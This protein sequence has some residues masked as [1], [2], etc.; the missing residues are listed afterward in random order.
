MKK[1]KFNL[2]LAA[3]ITVAAICLIS[4]DME[5]ISPFQGRWFHASSMTIK[6]NA[7]EIAEGTCGTELTW[8]LSD[9]ILTIT[10]TG[11]M[12]NWTSYS[13]A[14]WDSYKD[15]I[16]SVVINSGVTSVGN[17]AFYNCAALKTVSLPEEL[18]SIGNYAFR[19]CS[20]LATVKLPE[21]LQTIGSNAFR[22]CT[23]LKEVRIPSGVT[24]VS[25]SA[26][27]DGCTSLTKVIFGS[28]MTKVPGNICREMKALTTVEYEEA[29]EITSIG[30]YAFYNCSALATMTIPDTVVNVE[31]N[32][33]QGCSSLA[34]VTLPESMETIGSYAFRYCTLLG[35]VRIP[36]GVTS[37]S[38]SAPFDGC[39]SLTKVIF[40]SGMT[41]VPGNICRNMKALTT[42]VYE[43]GSTITSIGSYAFYNCSALTT[44]TIPDTV[45]NVENNAFQDC[46]SL[47]TVTLPESLQTIGNNAFR[48]C[49]FLGEVRIPS[50]V[51]SVS[52]SAPFDGC[53]ALTKVTFGKGITKVP[54]NICRNMTALTTVEYEEANGITE[55]GSYAFYNCSALTT[56]PIPDT[57]TNVGSY[58]FYNCT[59]L[60]IV[61]IP[62]TVTTVENY[63]FYKCSALE[64]VSLPEGLTSIGNYAFQDC[65]SLTT[66]KLPESLT[67]IGN[68]AFRDCTSLGEVRIPSGVTSVSGSAPFTGCTALTKVIFGSGIT[69]VPENIC[70]E[71]KALTT[72][73][74]EEVDEI[75][76]IGSYAFYNCSA[77]A[78]VTI[79]DTVTTVGNNAFNNCSA[80]KE[81]S[82][83]EGL[84]SI[85][86]KAFQDCSSLAT[87]TLPESLTSI[88]N[89][90]FYSCTSL[91]KIRIPSAVTTLN[92]YTFYECASLETVTISGD[93]SNIGRYVFYGCNNLKSITFPDSLE[94]I[95]DY[96]FYNCGQL[97]GIVLPAALK[98]L[99]NYAFTNCS[100]ITSVNLEDTSITNIGTQC[101]MNCSSIKR[102]VI[103]ESVDEV[104]RQ[105]FSGCSAAVSLTIPQGVKVLGGGC[106]AGCTGLTE[107][108]IP[109][110]VSTAQ[111]SSSQGPFSGCSNLTKVTFA[112]KM[113]SVPDYLFYQC[114]Q[115]TEISLP[116]TISEIGECAFYGCTNL[117]KVN[118]PSLLYSVGEFA[119]Y[120]CSKITAAD[121]SHSLE[122]IGRSAFSGC[123]ALTE[124]SF[125]E[126]I[127]VI[128][129]SCFAG[130][131]LQKVVLPYAVSSIDSN[132]FSNINTLQEISIPAG[133]T[134]IS[135]SAFNQESLTI[136]GA[137]GSRAE[138]Y[139]A[140][141]GYTFIQ[142]T[143]FTKAILDKTEMTLALTEKE[144]LSLDI[145]PFDAVDAI[146][147]TSENEEIVKVLANEDNPAEAVVTGVSSGETTIKVKAGTIE[148]ICKIMVGNYVTGI[149]LS[150]SYIYMDSLGDT[151]TLTA[152]VVPSDADNAEIVWSSAN[153]KVAVVDDKGNITAV[154]N[155]TV[156]ITAATKD[157]SVKAYCF[158]T[159][160]TEVPA[161]SISISEKSL[162]L[163]GGSKTLTATV[164]PEG[165]TNSDLEWSSSDTAVA[166]VNQ[167]GVVTAVADGTATITVQTT[168]NTVSAVCAVTVQ[169]V[170]VPVSGIELS[171]EE[172]ELAW[173]DK[174]ASLTAEIY[175]D[176][177][178]VKTIVWE[179]SNPDV[180]T[181]DTNGI[182]TATGGGTTVITAK[183]LDGGYTA[184]CQVTV[185]RLIDAL[186]L[187]HGS[188]TLKVGE[189]T[190]LKV[191]IVPEK[192]TNDEVL[193]TS[194]NTNIVTVSD[195]GR[196]T[197]VAEGEAYIRCR[198]RDASM[199][200]A[201]CKVTVDNTPVNQ[202]GDNSGESDSGHNS[203][204]DTNNIVEGSG[205]TNAVVD[206]DIT[207]ENTTSSVN[208]KTPGKVKIKKIVAANK[209]L[210]VTW[211]KLKG[212]DGYQIQYSANKKFKSSKTVTIKK[213]KTVTK[214]LK[215]LKKRKKYF[216][217]VRAYA[218]GDLNGK[219][220]VS[221]GKWSAVKKQTTK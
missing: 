154:G 87:V 149:S 167:N 197:A 122:S 182:I 135:S 155:G 218:E 6:A 134:S 70:R 90:A 80:L 104:S 147:W 64:T 136:R 160:E 2:A 40:G 13:V 110:S 213:A 186:T 209:K 161:E 62:G 53:T 157:H 184:S 169:L 183:T 126:Y 65:S 93:L 163:T 121:L 52:S 170:T 67:T 41:K 101:F 158:V 140:E 127:K 111:L 219:R 103:P 45:V 144:T 217:R 11:S 31:N 55:I 1:R 66:V 191:T 166:T 29:D 146:T 42:V 91:G 3:G 23:F 19:D 46:S 172:M 49:T 141:K 85:E 73:E 69:K 185:I 221:Y 17:Y 196:V 44:V 20:S 156:R 28:G 59:A 74:Y 199:E 99:G 89:Y 27:F 212:V 43:E 198:A 12:T 123:S 107:V 32:A 79:P 117:Q 82:L 10:G 33:F 120:N 139:A 54:G 207:K 215:K 24:S 56:A 204:D 151:G 200:M 15:S 34:T 61:T 190:N 78:T 211:K 116:D 76:S 124:V 4:P 188:L 83:P 176:N 96:A 48:N 114:D 205:E 77:L 187:D 137:A 39:T 26:P 95:S 208:I 145:T 68:N 216:V 84:T 36:S 165:A 148:R 100:K 178:D 171:A 81:V 150:K 162:Y 60:A 173:A 133:T 22:D 88:G 50:G 47:A 177:A 105:A 181:V 159:V 75:T 71:M 142:G 30:S 37:V 108:E 179:S 119:F 18:T 195:T 180:A 98:T 92:Q 125:S 97:E 14:P 5:R 143:G 153:E 7:A 102:I 164:T 21:S 9:G 86:N 57:V 132:A 203:F 201:T 113:R 51:T 220:V 192:V 94:S 138:T 58:A 189:S 16:T 118:M 112:E 72:V 38:G 206:S 35:E 109:R 194:S 193:W 8:K 128:P 63:A 152:S 210:K 202:G 129:S 168:D 115:L 25:S 174:T 175:P 214:T 130:T 131:A 106:F